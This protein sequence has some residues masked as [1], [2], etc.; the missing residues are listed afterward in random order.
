[1]IENDRKNDRNDQI[2]LWEIFKKNANQY[3]YGTIK[4]NDN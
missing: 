1:M 3:H 4:N 2:R